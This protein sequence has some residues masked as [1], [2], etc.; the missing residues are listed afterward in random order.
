MVYINFQNKICENM[1][2]I[3][4]FFN[5][6]YPN[7]DILLRNA[8]HHSMRL[9]AVKRKLAILAKEP[10]TRISKLRLK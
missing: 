9:I 10:V 7:V 4:Y 6:N 3:E 5:F 1:K 8:F 2:F